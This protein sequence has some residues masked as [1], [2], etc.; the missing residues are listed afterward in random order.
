MSFEVEM[1]V[2]PKGLDDLGQEARAAITFLR[3][4][5]TLAYRKDDGSRALGGLEIV[6][7]E[8]SHIKRGDA[9]KHLKFPHNQGQLAQIFGH[10]SAT[11]TV[12]HIDRCRW[13]GDQNSSRWGG[14][15]ANQGLFQR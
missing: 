9:H 15:A 6:K 10:R 7:E 11:S 3:Y 14:V 12:L 5:L 4:A 8:L 2:P 1:I 13:P